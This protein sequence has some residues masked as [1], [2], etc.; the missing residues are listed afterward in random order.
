MKSGSVS[1]DITGVMN[2]DLV[3]FV[4]HTPQV[5]RAHYVGT[6]IIVILDCSVINTMDTSATRRFVDTFDVMSAALEAEGIKD[7]VPETLIILNVKD[8]KALAATFMH[9]GQNGYRAPET[10]NLIACKTR[11][12]SILKLLDLINRVVSDKIDGLVKGGE[13]THDVAVEFAQERLGSILLPLLDI[14]KVD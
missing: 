14:V 9:A 5:Y 2:P 7:A 4:S 6:P 12:D 13:W 1:V 8:S 3:D 11:T 10:M